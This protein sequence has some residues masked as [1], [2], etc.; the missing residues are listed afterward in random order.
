M[1]NCFIHGGREDAHAVPRTTE[2]YAP[3]RRRMNLEEEVNSN[4]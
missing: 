1:F 3:A 2:R 4:Q